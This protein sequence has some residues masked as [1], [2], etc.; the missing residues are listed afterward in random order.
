VQRIYT[1][2][3]T[4][5][6]LFFVGLAFGA[7][8]GVASAD[9]FQGFDFFTTF[10]PGGTNATL[11]L[12]GGSQLVNFVG[13]P[14]RPD[15]GNTDTIVHRTG[16]PI[17]GTNL[18]SFNTQLN[19]LY[20]KSAQPV[21][22]VNSFFD[23]FVTINTDPASFPNVPQYDVLNPSTGSLT[24]TSNTGTGGTFNSIFNTVFGDIII[25]PVG[26]DP[27]NMSNVVFHGPTGNEGTLTSSGTIW[28]STPPKG[29]PSPP[30]FPSGGFFVQGRFM[31][32]G[33]NAMHTPDPATGAP[34]PA[35]MTLFGLGA[36]GMAGYAWRR[37]QRAA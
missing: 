1:W 17:I 27:T 4:W 26:A 9:V 20:L 10:A 32:T 12:P 31:E 7:S 15:L 29:Y 14:L 24:L 23:V 18:G 21:F 16:S 2:N 22:I 11:N 8:G 36:L 19:E 13:V 25:V 3:R 37:R 33:P 35:S 30:A 6:S 5:M 34:E 28:G